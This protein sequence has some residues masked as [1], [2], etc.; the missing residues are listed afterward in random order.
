MP[1]SDVVTWLASPNESSGSFQS[2]LVPE[3]SETKYREWPSFDQRGFQALLPAEVTARGAP[4][5]AAT[6]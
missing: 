4:P 6:T 1:I 2:W 5:E 3:R